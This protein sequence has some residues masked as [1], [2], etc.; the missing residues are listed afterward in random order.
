MSGSVLKL[1]RRDSKHFL[2]KGGFEESIEI[3]TPTK[4][5]VLALKG[6]ATK[7][8]ITFDS[9]GLPINSKNVHICVD[10]TFMNFMGYTTRNSRSEVALKNHLVSYPDSTGVVKNYQVKEC[11]P[12]ETLGLIVLILQDYKTV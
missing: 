12:D 3:S 11:F 8:W 1:A 6:Y 7:H 9:D 10:E 4:D 2:M 5:L